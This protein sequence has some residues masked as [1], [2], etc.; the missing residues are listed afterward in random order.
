ME[1]ISITRSLVKLKT[2]D[3]KIKKAIREGCY[4]SYEV[5]GKQEKT[6]NPKADYQSVVDLINYRDKLKTAVAE[7]N[8]KTKVKVAGKKMSVVEAI[9][10][11][12]SIEYKSELLTYL[13]H[14]LSSVREDVEDINQDVQ[15]RLDKLIEASVGS[16]KSKSEVE[17]ISKPF[18]QRNE[19]KVVDK[20]KI[21][22][23]I[24]ELDEEVLS[25]IED[26][27][28][29]LSEVNSQTFIEV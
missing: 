25:F 8:A 10:K 16:E 23:K 27:D 12:S 6:C 29:T 24:K 18:L 26:I 11:K 28:V 3:K 13:R 5:G 9:E 21:E 7:S 22:D 14:S 17:A 2:L 1:K 4:V 20:L 19:A 15:R